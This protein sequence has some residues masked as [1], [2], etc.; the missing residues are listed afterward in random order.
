[1]AEQK[2]TIYQKIIAISEEYLG[3]AGE[4]FMRRQIKTHLDI[5][6]EKIS[7]KHLDELANWAGLTFAVITNNA[8]EVDEFKK[9][10]SAVASREG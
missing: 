1:M 7:K 10:L 6:P 5:E 3:P 9:K 8:A 2:K 4:R